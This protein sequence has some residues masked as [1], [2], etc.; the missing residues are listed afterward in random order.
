VVGEF[1]IEHEG[2]L[3][4]RAFSAGG[5][6]SSAP[7]VALASDRLLTQVGGGAAVALNVHVFSIVTFQHLAIFGHAWAFNRQGAKK[8]LTQRRK[9]LSAVSFQPIGLSVGSLSRPLTAEC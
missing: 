5:A 9:E 3:A 7:K 6:P 1:C 8:G 2:I 4:Q